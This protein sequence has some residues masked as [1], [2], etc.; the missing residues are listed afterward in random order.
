MDNARQELGCRHEPI[1][2]HVRG[3]TANPRTNRKFK[4]TKFL[5]PPKRVFLKIE[6]LGE[7][8]RPTGCR[9]LQGANEL[10]RIRIGDY[11]VIYSSDDT[12][13]SIDIVAVRHR[14]Q[15]YD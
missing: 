4:Y 14:S 9:K 6:N 15:A 8:P 10:W 13:Q 12:E 7:L 3:P 11:R 2:D 5:T 1:R